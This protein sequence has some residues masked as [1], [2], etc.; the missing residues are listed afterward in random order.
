MAYDALYIG[1]CIV[2]LA[3][4]HE[5]C[6]SRNGTDLMPPAGATKAAVEE[7]RAFLNA[8]MAEPDGK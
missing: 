6:R 3:V 8:T 7:I 1:F 4:E 2:H 5:T